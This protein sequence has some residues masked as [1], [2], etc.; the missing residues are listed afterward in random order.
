MRKFKSKRGQSISV[1]SKIL[2]LKVLQL[3]RRAVLWVPFTRHKGRAKATSCL[4]QD[5]LTDYSSDLSCGQS[6]VIFPV[7]TLNMVPKK[8]IRGKH[9]ALITFGCSE[10][11]RGSVC[12]CHDE[13]A[14]RVPTEIG[15]HPLHTAGELTHG[16]LDLR[17]VPH[18][19]EI[20]PEPTLREELL[21]HH[22]GEDVA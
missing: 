13:L 20:H 10:R 21:A 5:L 1:F 2:R 17:V 15:G 11:W 8:V 3:L 16:G 12:R 4:E 18:R 9:S 22:L 6:H 7:Q 14:L 19:L